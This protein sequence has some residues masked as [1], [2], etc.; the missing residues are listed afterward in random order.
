[1][2]SRNLRP[3]HDRVVG[4]GDLAGV[5]AIWAPRDGYEW[6]LRKSGNTDQLAA[7]KLVGK[8]QRERED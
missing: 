8:R 3:V 5:D 2:G 6:Q 1:M 4:A 7:V